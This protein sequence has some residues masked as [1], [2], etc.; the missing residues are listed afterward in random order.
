MQRILGLPDPAIVA[1]E[2]RI[3]AA[4]RAALQSVADKI[5]DRIASIQVAS[6]RMPAMAMA[7]T[8]ADTPP[9]DSVPPGDGLPPGQPYV[10]PDELASVT[11]MWQ[12]AVEQQLLPIVAQI[13]MDAAGQ[14]HANMVDATTIRTLP[15]V[16]SLAAEQYLAQA[17]A[18][19]DMIG[20]DLWETSRSELL[21][22]FERGESI[23]QLAE[24]I[25]GSAGISARTS[26]LVARTQVIEASNAGSYQTAVVSGIEMRKVWIATP[27]LRTRP[28]HLAAD[29]A[30]NEHPVPLTDNFV[31]G[32]YPAMFPAAPSLP[33]AERYN[34]RCTIGYVMSDDA[35]AKAREAA[36]PETPLPGTSGA[37]VEAVAPKAAAPGE[38][39][40]IPEGLVGQQGASSIRPALRQTTPADLSRAWQAEMK[41]VTGR[42]IIVQI[43][44]AASMATMGQ[45]AEATVAMLERFPEMRLRKISWFDADG[46]HYARVRR[47]TATLEFNAR[48]AS[49]ENRRAYLSGLR[50]DVKGWTEPA[51]RGWSVRGASTPQATAY[52]ELG[53]MLSIET[54][55]GRLDS[56]ALSI[57]HR[58][59]VLEGIA[60]DELVAR[61]ISAYAGSNAEEMIAEAFTDVVLNGPAA[62]QIS[63]ELYEMITDEYRRTG[64]A[65]RTAPLAEGEFEGFT[66]AG[67]GEVFP[68]AATP[69]ALSSQTVAQLRALAKQRGIAIPAGARKADLVKALEAPVATPG[70]ISAMESLDSIPLD[71]TRPTTF[72]AL[73]GSQLTSI[74][75]YRTAF[76]GPINDSLRGMDSAGLVHRHGQQAVDLIPGQVRAID[77]AFDASRTRRPI[78]AWR[79]IGTGKDIFGDPATWPD[80]L[81]DFAWSDDAYSSAS[82]LEDQANGFLRSGG[83]RLHMIVPP[84]SKVIKLSGVDDEAEI[85]M[86]R[87]ASFRVVRDN[88]WIEV[89]P[90]GYPKS[91]RIRDL[92]VE[93][94]IPDV[95]PPVPPVGAR[96]LAARKAAPTSFESLSA[97]ASKGESAL[98]ATPLD[99]SSERGWPK[100]PG[101]RFSPFDSV[102]RYRG[103]EFDPINQE[104]RTGG[105][106]VSDSPIIRGIDTAMADSP[107]RSSVLSY[108]GLSERGFTR[109]SSLSLD[110]DLTGS[111][112]TNP[113]YTSTGVDEAIGRGFANKR[114]GVGV[115]MRVVSP[116]G[117]GAIAISGGEAELLLQ[118]GLTFQVVKDHGLEQFGRFSHRV[119]DVRVV[120]ASAT[121]APVISEGAAIRAA[122]RER[123]RLIESSTSTSRLLAKIDE[124]V[125]GKA[126]KAIIRQELDPALLEAEQLYAGADRAVV[127]SLRVAL[128]TGD[129]AKLRAA[130]TRAG[131]K[132]KIKPV[133]R[134][135]GKAIFDPE[136]MEGVGGI[137]IE[138]GTPVT[139]VR[140]GSTLTLPDKTTMQIGR[141]QVT[142]VQSKV[143][144]IKAAKAAPASRLAT[145]KVADLRALAKERGIVIPAGARKPDLIKALEVPVPRRTLVDL[146]RETPV[147]VTPLPGGITSRVEQLTYSDGSR[148][149]LKD[150]SRQG[151]LAAKIYTDSED[152]S[153]DVLRVVGVRHPD[154]VR[155]SDDKILMDFVEGRQG[156]ATGELKAPAAIVE[157][158]EGRRLG[159]ADALLGHRDRG[160]G[161][162][163]ISPDGHII[164][165]DNG[166]AFEHGAQAAAGNPFASFI[167]GKN[168]WVDRI[169]LPADVDLAEIRRGLESLRSKFVDL[170]RTRNFDEMISRLD[171]IERRAVIS[172]DIERAAVTRQAGI[173]AA[174]AVGDLGAE[175]LELVDSGASARALRARIEASAKRLQTPDAVRDALLAQVDDAS[176]LRAAVSEQLGQAGID[177][178]GTAGKIVRFDRKTM[179]PIGGVK[180][181]DWVVIDRPGT[182]LNRESEAIQLAKAKVSK[183]SASEAA[184]ARA[185]SEAAVRDTYSA[186][187]AQTRRAA[188]SKATA[189]P[190][191][192]GG[193]QTGT[194]TLVERSDGTVVEKVYGQRYQMKAAEIKATVDA[195]VLGAPI[196]DAVGVRSAA[197]TRLASD[198]IASE[199]LEGQTGAELFPSH[200]YSA[201]IDP[202]FQAIIDSDDGRLMGIADYLMYNIDRNSGNWVKMAGDRLGSF[203]LGASFQLPE[204]RSP[205][206]VPAGDFTEWLQDPTTR[207]L[208]ATVDID[209]RDLAIIRTRLEALRPQFTEASRSTW[210]NTMM[211][212]LGELEKRAVGTRQRITP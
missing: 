115:F 206:K 141:A 174:R 84:D 16:G 123:N 100:L 73:R 195:E 30:T 184:Q 18:T 209:P 47:G 116:E 212:R 10:S 11:P 121:Q 90:P 52:H 199:Y 13:F 157:S 89:T 108:R 64:L 168:H 163:I 106:S 46:P 175:V 189:E 172:S 197:T 180:E 74:R 102:G 139:I 26:V 54:F 134:A 29:A 136:T 176:A 69:R 208:T 144:P 92:E 167:L 166:A 93:I 188:A 8:A 53:H 97:Q 35:I 124:L 105:P 25:R 178:V 59:A 181:G 28:T 61:D 86:A 65:L 185:E 12:S 71:L 127:D 104:L 67:L 34:C 77:E 122:A 196:V 57:V 171:E 111:T 207:E 153:A 137:T 45:Y 159:L 87:G 56:K 17:R 78:E 160:G 132:S 117:T 177:T 22:G 148:A 152:L 79:G 158:D 179:D 58:R 186:R 187:L 146:A 125:A 155:L 91:I 76:S 80:D 94:R 113:A 7:M 1:Y 70:A 193:G 20:Q 62:S 32:G 192:L 165:I 19:F 38:I 24:R 140:R 131:T 66:R 82:A 95:T 99:V 161:N 96:P 190:Q 85:L 151:Q 2:E 183:A 154:V 21:D 75:D 194:V 55:G 48:W 128:D 138:P 112:W 83:V 120:P 27:D 51:D 4:V 130:L 41:R 200:G 156:G 162:W 49:E 98:S 205:I 142:P 202:A 72:S 6:A 119:L 169:E 23:P 81:T 68:K 118:R 42:D 210:F 164:A 39:P 135:G 15:S 33:P 88:G 133:G 101:A 143:P 3:E 203:D 110:S 44:P 150:Y 107:L 198:R 63:R 170:G 36:I 43:P 126:T 182:T 31:V 201:V 5:A 114:D 149:V 191:R 50:N 37:E 9:A 103:P 14:T 60:D 40:P 173:D 211:R 129:P 204:F 145:M 109:E 147:D